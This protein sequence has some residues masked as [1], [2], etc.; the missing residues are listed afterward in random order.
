MQNAAVQPS[1][2][3]LPLLDAK[4]A[5]ELAAVFETLAND[6]RLRVLNVIAQS[7]ELSPTALAERVGMKPQAISKT[8]SGS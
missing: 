1:L 5:T 2:S 3:E 6:T 8:R 4:K 7:V